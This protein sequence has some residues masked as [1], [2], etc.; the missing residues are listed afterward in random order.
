MTDVDTSSFQSLSPALHASAASGTSVYQNKQKTWTDGDSAS[1]KDVLAIINPLQHIPIVGTIYR[2]ITGDQIAAMPSIIGGALFGGPVGFALSLAD[3]AIKSETGKNVGET[4]VAGLFGSSADKAAETMVADAAPAS[5][6]AASSQAA[7]PAK[8]KLS[9]D[10]PAPALRPGEHAPQPFA[11]G[12]PPVVIDLPQPKWAQAGGARGTPGQTP[13]PQ[14]Q[15]QLQTS[16]QASTEP[17]PAAAPRTPVKAGMPLSFQ[18]ASAIPTIQQ[19]VPDL[20]PTLPSPAKATHKNQTAQDRFRSTDIPS[21]ESEGNGPS[22]GSDLVSSPGG[23][24][25]TRDAVPG[26]MTTALDKYATM[27]RSRNAQG[28]PAQVNISS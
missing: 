10:I 18:S 25:I 3:N 1:F 4:V 12:K 19:Q 2:A 9:I 26:A 22:R 11:D 20:P 27:M 14:Q 5:S 28:A 6:Q 23:T 8:P 21:P 24:A 15:S 7:G 17:V 13:A 16:Q